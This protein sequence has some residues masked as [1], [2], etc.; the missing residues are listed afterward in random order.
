MREWDPFNP[1]FQ[2][3]LDSRHMGD[4]YDY[5]QWAHGPQIAKH[6]PL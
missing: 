3:F 5:D 4:K 6:P 2:S 1:E